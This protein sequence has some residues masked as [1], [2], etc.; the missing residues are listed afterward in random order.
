MS[1]VEQDSVVSVIYTGTF[2]ESGEVFD[3]NVNQ[4][5]LVFLVGH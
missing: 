4:Q 3:S 1:V 5:P 2:H